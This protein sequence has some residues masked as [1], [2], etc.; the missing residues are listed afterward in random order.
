MSKSNE[1]E[2]YLRLSIPKESPYVSF[3]PMTKEQ[4]EQFL[5]LHKNMDDVL[6]CSLDGGESGFD[7][8]SVKLQLITPTELKKEKISIIHQGCHFRKLRKAD[9]S[10]DGRDKYGSD[11]FQSCV[12]YMMFDTLKNN[13]SLIELTK[14]LKSYNDFKEV[15]ELK[16][17]SKV[18][19]FKP[20]LEVKR[21]DEFSIWVEFSSSNGECLSRVKFLYDYFKSFDEL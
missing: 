2:V 13:K 7:L 8:Q 9:E 1:P 19:S 10:D 4:G 20:P 12:N 21:F 17:D 11:L 15:K 14:D 6:I 3:I 18:Y 5:Y 16:I